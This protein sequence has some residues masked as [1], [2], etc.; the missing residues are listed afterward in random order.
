MLLKKFPEK[1]QFCDL[2]KESNVIPLCVEILA[3]TETPVSLL[4]K[5]YKNKGPVFLFES[6][7]GGERWGRYSFLGVSAVC[8]ITVYKDFVEVRKDSSC[9]CQGDQCHQQGSQK[10]GSAKKNPQGFV[11]QA[12]CYSYPSSTTS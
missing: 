4:K 10:G 6:V 12:Q 11:L 9:E 7:E 8:H 5:F 2:A 3:D 1:D